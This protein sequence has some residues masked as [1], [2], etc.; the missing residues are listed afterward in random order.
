MYNEYIM[1]DPSLFM[2]G[3]DDQFKKIQSLVDKFI[4]GTEKKGFLS[5]RGTF[6]AGKTLLLRKILYRIHYKIISNQYPKWKYSEHS[7][8]FVQSLGPL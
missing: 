8:I 6:G 2:V 1:K 3:R 7:Q 4:R 5:I